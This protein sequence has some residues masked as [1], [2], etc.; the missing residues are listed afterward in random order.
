MVRL[1]MRDG[2]V[3]NIIELE[4]HCFFKPGRTWVQSSNYYNHSKNAHVY[5]HYQ[6]TINTSN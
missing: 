6:N 1:P 3:F 4:A 2:Y 5:M